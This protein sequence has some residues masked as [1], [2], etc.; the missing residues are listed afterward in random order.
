MD[1]KTLEYMQVRVNDGNR[2]LNEIDR[3]KKRIKLVK[4]TR[5]VY[6]DGFKLDF[7]EEENYNFTT[8][9]GAHLINNFID[10]ANAEIKR[11]ESE[12]AEI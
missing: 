2:I 12:F 4:T 8:Y 7:L 11:L 6:T 9:A 10:L 1:I 3:W 5:G